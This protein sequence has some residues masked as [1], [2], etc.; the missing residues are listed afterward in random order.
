[1]RKAV[2]DTGLRYVVSMRATKSLAQL[3]GKMDI[4]ELVKYVVCKNMR[5]ADIKTVVSRCVCSSNNPL[6]VA[7]KNIAK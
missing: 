7:L 3:Y 4:E 6:F 2:E 1:V 5:Q